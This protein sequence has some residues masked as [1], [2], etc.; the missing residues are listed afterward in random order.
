LAIDFALRAIHAWSKMPDKQARMNK[1]YQ[2]IGMLSLK[3]AA[4]GF[5][6]IAKQAEKE[7]KKKIAGANYEDA[8]DGYQYILNFD[9]AKNCFSKAGTI[10]YELSNKMIKEKDYEGAI[11][12]FERTCGIYQ[13]KA[14]LI[15]RIITEQKEF[16]KEALKKL[17]EELD[18]AQ[19]TSKQCSKNKAL[20]HEKLAAFYLKQDTKE[21]KPIAEKELK[22]AY[23]IL[24]KMDEK[25][26][27]KRIKNK[28]K[29]IAK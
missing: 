2:V 3:Q 9:K 25:S 26:D 1:L 7:G 12:L 8:A 29:K 11:H 15:Q 28:L 22:R 6:N 19:Q 13:K 4:I 24:E 18:K 17:K 16:T 21:N 23:E 14:K 27:L 10:F 20:S 5:E